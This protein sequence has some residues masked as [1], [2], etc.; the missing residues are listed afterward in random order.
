MNQL[1]RDPIESAKLA[2]LKLLT[3]FSVEQLI[4]L[5]EAAVV[6]RDNAVIRKCSQSFQVEMNDKGYVR[7]FH[8]HQSVEAVKPSTYKA[9]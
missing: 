1:P 6:T 7:F 3:V 5:A 9:E 8:Y 2:T 4:Q